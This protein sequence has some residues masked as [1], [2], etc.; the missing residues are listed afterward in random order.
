MKPI[1]P[2]YERQ[3]C[4]CRVCGNVTYY[5]YVPY[6]LSNPIMVAPCGHGSAQRDLGHDRITAD[7]A[8]VSLS[9]SNR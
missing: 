2:G 5:D 4:R 1:S 6:S 3:W 8:I 7:E 9:Q